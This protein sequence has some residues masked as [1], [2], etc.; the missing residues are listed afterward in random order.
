MI[1]SS[2]FT[3]LVLLIILGVRDLLR[4][5]QRWEDE[6]TLKRRAGIHFFFALVMMCYSYAVWNNIPFAASTMR[7]GVTALQEN[8]G[9]FCF[10]FFS[11]LIKMV[12]FYIQIKFFWAV[13]S[14]LS[15]EDSLGIFSLCL[16]ITLSF[17]WTNAV[18]KVRNL[19]II[20]LTYGFFFDGSRLLSSLFR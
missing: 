6:D 3:S 18:V 5:P 20:L 1:K 12:I 7:S 14:T 19:S 9:V 17:Y 13:F 4:A 2:L 10:A 15:N 8:L 16:L 11:P